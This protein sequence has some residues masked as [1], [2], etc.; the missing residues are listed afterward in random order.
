MALLNLFMLRFHWAL[1]DDSPQQQIVRIRTFVTLRHWLLNYFGYDFMRSKDLRRTLNLQLQTLAKHPI[2]M[3]STRDQRIVR[4]LRRY[5]QSLKKIHYRNMAQQK[6]ERRTR[7]HD[8]HHRRLQARRTSPQSRRESC[9]EW[10]ALSTDETSND[11]PKTSLQDRT[12]PHR[13][14]HR[15]S[16]ESEPVTEELTVEFRSSDQSGD[17]DSDID[18]DFELSSDNNANSSGDDSEYSMLGGDNAE[19]E[20][21]SDDEEKDEAQQGHDADSESGSFAS[22]DDQ[23][24]SGG[25]F[26]QNDALGTGRHL[27][28]P[29]FSPRPQKS[30]QGESGSGRSRQFTA[31]AVS[32]APSRFR[33]RG[34]R[35]ALPDFEESIKSRTTNLNTPNSSY[36]HS[37][38]SNRKSRAKSRSKPLSMVSPV[39]P[40]LP[41]Q[42]G[43]P[44]S[45]R[46]SIRSIEPY[47]N[48]PPRST[49]ST[50]KKTTLSKYMSAT[51]DRLSKMKNV[52]ST[53]ARK[54]RKHTLSTT[55]TNSVGYSSKRTN[56]SGVSQSHS[57]RYRQ[58]NQSDPEGDKLSHYL[59][60]S[61]TGANMLV[62]SSEE[63]RHPNRRYATERNYH[64]EE[65]GSDWSSDDE[66]SQY[67]MTRRSSRQYHLNDDNTPEE[68]DIVGP[69]LLEARL[70]QAHYP[71]YVDITPTILERARIEVGSRHIA[72]HTG[73]DVDN[74]FCSECERARYLSGPSCLHP[75]AYIGADGSEVF[76]TEIT[77]EQAAAVVATQEGSALQEC[78]NSSLPHEAAPD[79]MFTSQGRMMWR[80]DSHD[81]L[82]RL[83]RRLH[84]SQEYLSTVYMG[85]RPHHPQNGAA[86]LREQLQYIEQSVSSQ[87]GQPLGQPLE[88]PLRPLEDRPG[89][90]GARSA[91][92]VHV[93]EATDVPA[94]SATPSMPQRHFTG[95]HE[96][97][98]PNSPPLRR[99][100]L[101]LESSMGR[102]TSDNDTTS[103]IPDRSSQSKTPLSDLDHDNTSQQLVRDEHLA[104]NSGPSHM[105]PVIESTAAIEIEGASVG[106]SS[107]SAQPSSLVLTPTQPFTTT[108]FS[109]GR[110]RSQPHLLSG[111]S[112]TQVHALAIKSDQN[113]CI[114]DRCQHSHESHS[115]HRL[116]TSRNR[117]LTSSTAPP[118]PLRSN[119][120][121]IDGHRSSEVQQQRRQGIDTFSQR[122]HELVTLTAKEPCIPSIVLWYRSELIAQQLCL[123]EREL[124]SQVQWYE[125]VDAGWTKNAASKADA[126]KSTVSL[127]EGTDHQQTG[128]ERRDTDDEKRSLKSTHSN[129]ASTATSIKNSRNLLHQTSSANKRVARRDESI[130]IKRL[131]ERFNLTCQWVASEIVRTQNL[132]MRVKVVEKFI[133]I[134]YTCY[135]HSNFSSLVQIT[136][137]LQTEPVERLTRTWARVR[138]QEMRIM[139][140]LVEFT[141][142]MRNWKH[143]R[144]AMKNIADEWGGS[145]NGAVGPASASVSTPPTLSEKPSGSGNGVMFFNKKPSKPRSGEGATTPKGTES[146]VSA[147][148]SYFSSHLFHQ[149]GRATHG[150]PSVLLSSAKGKERE[151]ETTDT[152]RQGGCI[153]FL[154]LYLS[155]LVFNSELPSYVEPAG[156]DSQP[157]VNVHKHR[158]TAT[159]IKRILTFRTMAGR[160]PFRPEPKVREQLM[161]IEG[162]ERAELIRL[163]NLCEERASDAAR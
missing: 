8:E 25:L 3:D 13:H 124:L 72:D 49:A 85:E 136:V 64:R 45:D 112:A 142:P 61:C 67:E 74:G 96:Q 47:I 19:D 104:S 58:R 128:P 117:A 150:F 23:S 7:K 51:V 17:G 66:Y 148:P 18:D 133:R 110:S 132:D 44:L 129:C 43:S 12:M 46:G 97:Q 99:H 82:E 151:K 89:P 5:A 65:V 84:K 130:G 146:T 11:H 39:V 48:P 145:G 118:G 73:S 71:P 106:Q 37:Q 50:E 36:R 102:S 87:I 108:G 140:D 114:D 10:P 152:G 100:S 103:Q 157:M 22:C 98:T 135:N 42:A 137:A 52:F 30:Q 4:E 16:N 153:P 93:Q 55:S 115:P 92:S 77:D 29:A 75:F 111:L 139:R 149:K 94:Q 31:S 28:S 80:Q 15:R 26:I 57:R 144:D 163:S 83:S 2:V 134:A 1:I 54:N 68:F 21:S 88:Q 79:R 35:P 113:S 38:N 105:Q 59:L 123:I 69:Q 147:L 41:P 141:M 70:E 161:A 121:F 91:E 158:T 126:K 138:A 14:S 6:L 86:K 9:V 76:V 119:S 107:S 53:N 155:D 81:I 62:S 63:R 24:P 33:T 143:L 131:V 160:Y 154:A 95:H 125:L 32:S 40:S 156:P 127:A 159:I 27:P 20:D 78:Q 56:A 162:L 116:P 90:D 60:G 34:T 122:F 109:K 120:Y 101:A